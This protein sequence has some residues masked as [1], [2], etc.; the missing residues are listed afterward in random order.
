GRARASLTTLLS[1]MMSINDRR[2][3]RIDRSNDF[4]VL[5]R[6][7]AEAASE[8][9]A[10]RLWRAVFG[11]CPARYLIVNDATLDDHEAQDVN[12]GKS[13]LDAPPLRISPRRR[14]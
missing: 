8:A 10:H 6:W 5:A 11:L 3:S 4:R 2:I 7:F 12:D 9:D 13:W 14:V 1:V